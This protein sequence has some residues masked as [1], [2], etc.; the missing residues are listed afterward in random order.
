M[1]S[2]TS[3]SPRS[4]TDWIILDSSDSMTLEAAAMST[5]SRTSTSDANGPSAKPRPGVTALP[6]TMSSLGRGPRRVVSRTTGPAD[7]S[8]MASARW[9]PSVRGPTPMRT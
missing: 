5:S 3:V 9:R 2:R 6:R 8:A 7:A 1:T 4:K